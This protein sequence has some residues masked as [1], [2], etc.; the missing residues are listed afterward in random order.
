ML[1]IM[2]LLV[3]ELLSGIF[4]ISSLNKLKTQVSIY[5][6]FL[7]DSWAGRYMPP[8]FPLLKQIL[9]KMLPC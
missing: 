6:V 4:M 8:I 3:S 7:F 1:N 9:L 2:L 5:W